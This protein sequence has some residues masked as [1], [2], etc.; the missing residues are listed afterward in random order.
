MNIIRRRFLLGLG[1]LPVA[2]AAPVASATSISAVQPQMAKLTGIRTGRHGTFDRI[3]LDM[4]GPRLNVTR[5]WG[6]VLRQ[7]GS[8]KLAWL[9]GCRFLTVRVEPAVAH[10]AQGDPTLSGPRK[11]RT[12]RLSNVMA[13][14]LVGDF[15]GVVSIGIGARKQKKVRVFT[16]SSPTR[17]VIDIPH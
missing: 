9:Y 3:V 5:S 16:L 6:S 15:E 17:V 7:D 14:A 1:L 4:R 8:G 11:F 13:V 10:D 12:P 2:M